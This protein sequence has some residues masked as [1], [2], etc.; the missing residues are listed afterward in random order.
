MKIELKLKKIVHLKMK[1]IK[2]KTE[3]VIQKMKVIHLKVKETRLKN[4]LMIDLK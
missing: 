4:R 2:L 3:K 1:M